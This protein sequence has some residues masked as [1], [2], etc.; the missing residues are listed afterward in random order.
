MG[1]KNMKGVG[2]GLEKH[3][4]EVRHEDF[5]EGVEKRFT[6]LENSVHRK[7]RKGARSLERKA[8]A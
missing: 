5:L 1:R 6:K 3:A 8:L 2:L 4:S 7:A